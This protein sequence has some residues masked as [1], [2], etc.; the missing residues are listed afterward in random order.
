MRGHP[1]RCQAENPL[2]VLSSF[3]EPALSTAEGQL[4][5]SVACNNLNLVA[6]QKVLEALQLFQNEIKISNP[7]RIRENHDRLLSKLFLAMREDLNIRPPD[8]PNSFVI[9]I[10]ASGIKGD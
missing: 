2:I 3:P 9:R 4:A 10:W 7:D 6:P 5:F 1:R 8:E